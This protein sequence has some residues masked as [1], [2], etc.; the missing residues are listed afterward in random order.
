MRFCLASTQADWGGGEKLLWSIRT[1][2]MRQ[3]HSVTWIVRRDQ[4]LHQRVQ[5]AGDSVLSALTRRGVNPREWW[6]V[7]RG[8]NQHRPDILLLN[9]S[10][11]IMLG[12]SAALASRA[13]PV[14]L[15]FRHVTFPIRSP[16]KLRMMSDSIVCVS[17]AAQKTVLDAGISPRRT[18]VIYGG[19]EPVEFDPTA[20]QWADKELKIDPQVPLL[21]CV[22]NL[23]ECK[24][25]IPLLEAAHLLKDMI[26]DYQLAIAGEGALRSELEK[27]IHQYQ[28]GYRV[29]LL[30]FRHDADRWLSAASVVIHP[31]LQEG[32]SLVLIQAQMLR[33][34]IV[35]T[36]VG[37]SSEVLGM[38]EP[39]PCPMWKATPNDAASLAESIV[40]AVSAWQHPNDLLTKQL[41]NAALRAHTKFAIQNNVQ[42]LV[43]HCA[44]LVKK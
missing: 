9:D 33:K 10:H 39:T 2:L 41:H 7:V 12:G 42:Q 37:G 44:S 24:G 36:G 11:A 5:A 38:S 3:G 26:P 4:P 18:V 21:V 1:E 13:R 35:S 16:L 23:L 25:H 27:L 28:L 32:L 31:S 15:A 30:G 19:C 8:L 34:I 14:R 17:Q 6:T 29:H 40:Q 22:G 20:R 43:E